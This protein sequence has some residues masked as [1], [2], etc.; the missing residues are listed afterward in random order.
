MTVGV[1]MVT[2]MTEWERRHSSVDPWLMPKLA[3][4]IAVRQWVA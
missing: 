1:I 3:E 4:R 2:Y